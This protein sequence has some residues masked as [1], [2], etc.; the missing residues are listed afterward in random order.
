MACRSTRS[1]GPD[2]RSGTNGDSAT[3]PEMGD[4]SVCGLDG[5]LNGAVSSG[6]FAARQH[7]LQRNGVSSY[8]LAWK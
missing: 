2:P 3:R 1:H 7:W 6:R 5:S 4:G 8:L